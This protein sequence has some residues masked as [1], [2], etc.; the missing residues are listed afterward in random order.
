VASRALGNTSIATTKKHY[1]R[2]VMAK[3]RKWFSASQEAD[4]FGPAAHPN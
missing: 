1:D 3:A 2:A 4:I